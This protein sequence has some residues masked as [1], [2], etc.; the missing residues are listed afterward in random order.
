MKKIIYYFLVALFFIG[1]SKKDELP[2][3]KPPEI[4]TIEVTSITS[5]AALSGG[6]II[7]DGGSP[8]TERGVC[9]S[10]SPSPTI[11]DFTTEG[12]KGSGKF[13][14]NLINLESD[15]QY[16]L[17]AYAINRKGISYGN[18]ISFKTLKDPED[19]IYTGNLIFVTQQEVDEFAS[20][21]YIEIK[22]NVDFGDPNTSENTN[23]TDLSGLRSIKSID[24]YL[25]IKRN[26]EL[27]SLDGLENISLISGNLD[28]TN[29]KGL[30]NINGL[31]GLT[32]LDEAVY[33][34]DNY[35]LIDLNGLKNISSIQKDLVILNNY[36]LIDLKGLINLTFIG[37]DLAIRV[38]SNWRKALHRYKILNQIL[39]VDLAQ[40]ISKIHFRF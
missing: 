30:I 35:S 7:N 2:S 37:G 24:G 16:Y 9:W 39:Y 1:C 8:V 34:R 5:E 22:G 23:I 3:S 11:E 38:F 15:T 21:G 4:I 25:S 17:R 12:G 20:E 36:A 29:N 6:N 40:L 27:I 19:L 18:N 31:T 28:I 14:S 13:S 26:P 33:L 32:Q 10:K